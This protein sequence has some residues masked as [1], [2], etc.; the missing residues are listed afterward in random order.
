VFFL[1]ARLWEVTPDN[2]NRLNPRRAEPQS[3]FERELDPESAA[4]EV[5]TWTGQST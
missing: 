2:G 3:C 1:M 4:P 5:L